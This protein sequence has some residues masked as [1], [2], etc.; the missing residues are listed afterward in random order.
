MC[1][2]YARAL[3]GQPK[4]RREFLISVILDRLFSVP[5]AFSL[6]TALPL[7]TSATP[8]APPARPPPWRW[9]PRVVVGVERQV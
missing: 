3:T 9:P 2:A 4:W 8:W 1:F 7:R 5:A 6:P